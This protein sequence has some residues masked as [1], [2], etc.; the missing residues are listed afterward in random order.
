MPQRQEESVCQKEG[1]DQEIRTY[2]EK[3]I[4]DILKVI[5]KVYLTKECFVKPIFILLLK[6]QIKTR[7][8]IFLELFSILNYINHQIINVHQHN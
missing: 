1:S 5:C 8:L 6:K 4:T 3:K 7:E 2:K